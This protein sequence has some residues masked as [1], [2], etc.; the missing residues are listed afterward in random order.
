MN[1]VIVPPSRLTGI[2][3]AITTSRGAICQAFDEA[4]AKRIITALEMLDSYEQDF[5]NEA[6]EPLEVHPG[7]SVLNDLADEAE[8]QTKDLGELPTIHREEEL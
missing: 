7:P 3:Y 1:Y 5:P 8:K 2:F 6:G 4:W